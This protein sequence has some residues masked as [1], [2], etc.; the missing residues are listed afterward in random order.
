MIRKAAVPLLWR[1]VVF[2]LFFL[3][4]SGTL[5][6]RIIN[7]GLVHKFGF[8]VYGG[9]GKAL[10]FGALALLLLV[11]KRGLAVKLKPWH[12]SSS[13][14]LVLALVACCLAW[15]GIDKLIA[16][17]TGI[18]WQLLVHFGLLAAVI[19]A[20]YGVFGSSNVRQLIEK[21]RRE[22]LLAITLSV[23]FF[24]FLYIVYGLWQIMAAIV[25]HTVSW[26]LQLVGVPA[27]IVPPRTL[28]LSKFG[29]MV[30]RTCSGI[31]SVALFTALYVLVGLLDWQ[32][33]NHRKYYAVFLP[34]LIVLFG[35]NI[36]RVFGLIVAGYDINP[37]IAFSLFH[38]Y[39]GMVFFI[40]YSMAFW[41]ISYKWMLRDE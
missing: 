34:A 4:I 12:W 15:V 1:T 6:L 23:V 10:L 5:G 25:L 22:L 41:A 36:L 37:H 7:H 32:R 16:G 3:V 17:T 40:I 31:E 24:G 29:I 13:V 35:L 19:G 21:Y 39:A 26:L 38:T 20:L 14:W 33:F 30:A 28:V 18:G 11:G 2:L 27:L 8:E 9:A